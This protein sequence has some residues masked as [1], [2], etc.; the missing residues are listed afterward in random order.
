MA[1]NTFRCILCWVLS[2]RRI[3]YIQWDSQCD[4][5]TVGRQLS[6]FNQFTTIIQFTSSTPSNW[7]W[8]KWYP[9][10]RIWC[11]A[12]QSFSCFRWCYDLSYLCI[13]SLFS[14]GYA[15]YFRHLGQYI[16][17]TDIRNHPALIL[18]NAL[19]VQ[20][21]QP[22]I[23]SVQ[24]VLPAPSLNPVNVVQPLRGQVYV[25]SLFM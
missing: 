5:W 23:G 2:I 12:K 7:W 21:S 4:E 6:K 24:S 13:K 20:P 22:S 8:F 11:S 18:P 25:L 16:S 1:L 3:K 17:C 10:W 15:A 9:Y 19:T 14:S